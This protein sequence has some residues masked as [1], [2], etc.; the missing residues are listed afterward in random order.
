M[1]E[2]RKDGMI[3]RLPRSKVGKKVDSS[4]YSKNLLMMLQ[5]LRIAGNAKI[6]Y[7]VENKYGE[8]RLYMH[9]HLMIG[10]PL[11]EYCF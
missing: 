6:L 7:P 11:S 2:L 9:R 4:I 8:S 10:N 3:N 1:G 5:I